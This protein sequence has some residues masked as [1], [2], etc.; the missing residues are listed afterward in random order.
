VENE[1]YTVLLVDDEEIVTTSISALL[2]LE[3]DYDV[4]VF[5]SPIEALEEMQH[6]EIDLVISD[7]L[8][9]DMN[10]VEF[11]MEMKKLQPEAIRIILTA[12]A[13]KENAIKAVNEVGLYQFVE[14]PWDN[15]ALLLLIRNGLRN[16]VLL[17]QLRE[18]MGELDIAADKL[19]QVQTEILKAFI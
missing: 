5:N 12:Y 7:Y 8:M 11:L 14:K 15:D 2:M 3:T 19:Q 9:P 18:K 16:R 6:E 4:L 13:D 10:G 1:E 17:Q